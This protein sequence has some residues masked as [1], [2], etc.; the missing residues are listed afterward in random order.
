MKCLK[1][2]SS[3][4]IFIN[5][6]APFDSFI[7][8]IARYAPS[9]RIKLKIDEF[10]LNR[11]DES[12][13]LKILRNLSLEKSLNDFKHKNNIFQLIINHKYKKSAWETHALF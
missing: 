3:R 1:L 10:P 6:L 8:R 2:F 7:S 4:L 11:N 12:N 13:S 9:S 5:I